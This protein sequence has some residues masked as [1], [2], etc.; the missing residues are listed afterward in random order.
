MKKMLLVTA[1]LAISVYLL[2]ETRIDLKELGITPSNHHYYRL[3]D[4]TPRDVFGIDI[5]RF[6]P[7]IDYQRAR[8]NTTFGRLAKLSDI[9]AIGQVVAS[10]SEKS[11]F[12]VQVETALLGCTNGQTIVVGILTSEMD[13]FHILP[14]NN[15]HIVF[16]AFT[17]QYTDVI[18]G[19]IDWSAAPQTN[20]RTQV[21]TNYLLEYSPRSFWHT[22]ED[23][24]LVTEQFTNVLQ[25]VRFERNWT[26]Y[27]HLCRDGVNS[28]SVRVREDSFYDL[29]GLIKFADTNQA[30]FIYNDPLVSP[31]HKAYL[32]ERHPYVGE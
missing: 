9:I 20:E 15:T 10:D 5:L 6:I 29:A 11:I 1:S 17:N 26:N 28:P 7:D 8:R 27:Y 4:K 24:G 12:K 3:V 13:G 23:N 19:Y 14:T 32:L 22:D 31:E 30:H 21:F 16:S 18:S 2:A 25:A